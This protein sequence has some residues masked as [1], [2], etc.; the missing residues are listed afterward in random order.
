MLCDTRVFDIIAEGLHKQ[1]HIRC[2]FKCLLFSCPHDCQI[3]K[4]RAYNNDALNIFHSGQTNLTGELSH[5]LYLC[6]VDPKILEVDIKQN[7][8]SKWLN[9][10][11][12]QM[13]PSNICR[14]G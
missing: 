2:K 8:V 10:N 1:Y 12:N 5:T 4:I 11:S 6:K 9:Q 14:C 3:A 13:Q 7:L